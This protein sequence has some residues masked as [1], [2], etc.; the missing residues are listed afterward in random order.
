MSDKRHFTIVEGKKEHGLFVST[1]PSGAARKVVSKLSK[2]KKVT[3][4]LREITQG[5]KKKVYG[6][7]EGMKK[8]LSKPI[9][10]GDRV[11][12]YEP[13][14]KK[15]DDSKVRIKINPNHHA[16][17]DH[18]Y[19]HVNNMSKSARHVALKKALIF[20]QNKYGKKDGYLK[21]IHQMT[22]AEVLLKTSKPDESKIIKSDTKW[23]SGLYRS[24]KQS[25]GE[26]EY[27]T[28]GMNTINRNKN[29]LKSER[30]KIVK[31]QTSMFSNIGKSTYSIYIDNQLV[32]D[33]LNVSNTVNLLLERY[34]VN[35]SRLADELRQTQISSW[36]N[37]AEALIK[38]INSEEEKRLKLSYLSKMHPNI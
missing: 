14:V 24:Y 10:V 8:K 20:L 16:L 33:N 5:S 27:E 17:S 34:P 29:I 11:Y 19:T 25:G 21:L 38:A 6:P 23:V 7:Y 32:G 2:G 35:L 28:L 4:S 31:H 13:I 37:L 26:I 3:F 36:R 1:T 12:K 9:K 15:V 30:L 18:G 22:A